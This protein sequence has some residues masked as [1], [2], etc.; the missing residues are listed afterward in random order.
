MSKHPFETQ[1]GS[2][3]GDR[4]KAADSALPEPISG[5]EEI[6]YNLWWSWH[7]EALDLFE[8]IDPE[9]WERTAH[10]PVALLARVPPERL[11]QRAGDNAFV[12]RCKRVR[13]ALRRYLGSAAELE[14]DEALSA[15]RPVAYF[16]MEFCL[17]ECLPI[18][19]GGLGV[20]S[21]DHLKSASDLGIPLVAVGL[22][23]RQGYFEQR[24][25]RD[26]EQVERYPFLD[27]SNLPIRPL[28]DE[29]GAERRLEVELAGRRVR[30][31]IWK[32]AVGRV[33]LYLLDPDVDENEPRDRRI[34][35]RLYG[36][37][38]RTRIEQEVLLGVGGVSLLE[39]VLG[40]RPGVY[41]LNEGHCAFL[42]FERVR[43]LM[44]SRGLSFPEAREAA[45]ASSVFTTHTPVPAGNETFSPELVEE[46]FGSLAREL[47]VPFDR[48][49]ETGR[50]RGG[51]AGRDFSM[52]VLALELSS[53]ANAVSKLH[54]EVCREMWRDVWKDVAVEETPIGSITNGVHL[55]SWIGLP[56]RRLLGQYLDLRWDENHDDEDAWG[57]VLEVP[58]ERL[59]VEHTSQKRTLLEQVERRVVEDYARR[60]E[61]PQLI[62]ETVE[63][64]SPRKLTVG[65][66]RRFATYKR[67]YLLFSDRE[68][69][70]RLVNHPERPVQFLL[71][72]KAH[73][74]DEP[75]KEL[76][77]EVV[78][79]S[80]DPE[81]CG[82]VVYLKNYDMA[83][84]RLITQG[85][86]VWLNTPLRPHEASGT[87]GMKVV[88]NGGVNCSILDGWW[89]EAYDEGLGFAIEADA[90]FRSREQRDEADALA[91]FDLLEREIAPL[92]YDAG[93]DGVPGG[94]LRVMKRGLAELAP[95]FNT[96]R[97]VRQYNEEMY[98][99]AARGSKSA[100]F[101]R[102][103]RL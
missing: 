13:S 37:D 52:T 71:A 82:R 39:D 15:A 20:L 102:L 28:R 38:R 6:A 97:M 26:G 14:R 76:I 54:G 77:R 96:M 53:R 4:A 67:A 65:F 62:R 30:A 83:L 31:R 93:D 63:R 99:P 8:E 72:G 101:Q 17:H 43:R 87:S 73:P 48:L 49:A 40:L 41:H 56:M 11:E 79:A 90:A 75:G 57:Q 7:P 51:D 1:D 60:G 55:T 10:N 22:L 46:H 3:P 98:L 95:R 29:A 88:P 35:W 21:G 59:W 64:L 16:S 74:A 84:G 89:D 78:E 86:D 69:L 66:A 27:T 34:A 85:V 2:R 50:S 47:E 5:L 94:W 61:D 80:R 36:G 68:R 58:D 19:S 81:L 25:D 70:A 23:Y 33:E 45:K 18:Y 12:K 32:V 9:L 92:Y 103:Y 100:D 24:L 42:L 91:L 44:G